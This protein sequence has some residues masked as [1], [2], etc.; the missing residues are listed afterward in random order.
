ML[1][2]LGM[3]SLWDIARVLMGTFHFHCFKPTQQQGDVKASHFKAEELFVIHP[4]TESSLEVSTREDALKIFAASNYV[5]VRY[6]ITYFLG[7]IVHVFP[8]TESARVSAMEK[9]APKFQKW[10]NRE[11]F[12]D[13]FFHDIVKSNNPSIVVSNYGTFSIRELDFI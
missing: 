9:R 12:L 1:K 10:L 7:E 8:D 6:N 13:Y 3:E 4:V 2:N 5:V 11:D